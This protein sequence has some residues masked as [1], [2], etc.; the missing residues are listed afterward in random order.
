VQQSTRG[1]A[2]G[3]GRPQE[4]AAERVLEGGASPVS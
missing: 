4:G 2:L 1:G 3:R